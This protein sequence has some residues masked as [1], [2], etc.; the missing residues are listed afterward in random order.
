MNTILANIAVPVL[1]PQ[2]LLALVVLLP[3]VG[4]ETWALRRLIGVSSRRVF[5]AN[6]LSTL[7]GIP[8]A[9]LW[10]GLCN[11]VINENTGGW[12]TTG[13][14][15]RASL[16]DPDALWLLAVFAVGVILPCFVLS[17]V[18]EGVYLRKKLGL[19]GGRP[20]R[21]GICGAPVLPVSAP[22]CQL[23]LPLHPLKV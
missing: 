23:G 9:C 16:S 4:V 12:G 1:F 11:T 10:I 18:S 2:P 17:V 14:I 15:S 19:S 20:F 13:L 3:I 22:K 8:V 7:I 6:V 21:C 5:E